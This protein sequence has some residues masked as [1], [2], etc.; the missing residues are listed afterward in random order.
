[1]IGGDMMRN[2][3]IKILCV[4]LTLLIVFGLSACTDAP[5]TTNKNFDS[6]ALSKKL[7]DGEVICENEKF[8]LIWKSSNCG[9]ILK[10]KNSGL[11]WGPAAD[12]EG[13]PLVDALGMPIKKH[14]QVE[15]TVAIEYI[16]AETRLEEQAFSYNSAVK[17]GRVRAEKIDNG[18]CVEYYF[19]DVEIKIPVK[20]VL[21]EDSL[22]VS[23]DPKE[24]EENEQK[25]V[26]VSLMPFF[27]SAPNDS[28]DSYLF[29]PSG[30]GALVYP[31]TV[32]QKGSTYT[33][34]VYGADP[35]MTMLDMPSTEKNVLLPVYGAK[36]K[37]TASCAIIESAAESALIEAKIGAEAIKYT[38]VYAKF[39]VRGYCS[40]TARFMQGMTKKLNVYSD[41]MISDVMMVGYY[42][43][44]DEKANYSGMAEVYKNYLKSKGFLKDNVNQ[45]VL[46]VSIIG[47]ATVNKSFLGIP[48]KNLLAATTL[49]Q[50]KDILISLK[51]I[52]DQSINARLIGFGQGGL[53][54]SSYAGNF[55]IDKSLGD[56][57]DLSNLSDYC[58]EN[59]INL[60]FDFD[61]IKL[62]KSSLGF[63]KNFDVAH[64]A[65]NKLADLY[66]YNVVTRSRIE[67]SKYRLLSRELL[68]DGAE[69]MLNKIQKWNLK[70]VSLSSVS[71]VAYSDY[72]TDEN[73]KY[74]SKG[75]MGDDVTD[76]FNKI[77][78]SYKIS[79][80]SAN[81]Y[82]AVLSD[83]IYNSPTCSSKEISFGEDIPFYQ[84]V[85]KGYVS[86][87]S[88]EINLA[89]N[90]KT[91]LLKALESGCALNYLVASEYYNEFIDHN[92]Y[93]LAMSKFSDIKQQIANDYSF[94]SKCLNGVKSAEIVSHEILENGLRKTEFSNGVSVYVNYTKN[95]LESPLG[96]VEAQGYRWG[97]EDV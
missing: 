16:N 17:N 63:N 44:A 22:S 10:D 28:E 45:E 95:N 27:C 68:A 49:K 39:Q 31:K 94:V 64:S 35:T 43:L 6:K 71:S 13:E 20:Y 92:G 93:E 88:G 11:T 96:E 37:N 59:N 89:A 82:A 90:S 85:F 53:D 36:N 61:L 46:Y 24:I 47:G 74:Y 40:N 86:L 56:L 42:P 81:S 14:P 69:K 80:E 75:N 2:G 51:E 38:G 66:D 9:V 97:E 52:T 84:M 79:S 7:S 41:E 57:K 26:S 18:V 76:I 91:E 30:S 58:G 72:S 25:V 21:R 70:G 4:L 83:A 78:G 32:S 12:V 34:Q 65:T 87:S 73:T 1:M 15:S 54:N 23:V 67:E 48:Y 60:F 55:K 33:S 5:V 77:S 8:S 19:D 3:Y 50:S 29:Y 62:K